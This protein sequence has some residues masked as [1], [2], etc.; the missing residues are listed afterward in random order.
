MN[1]DQVVQ[2]VSPY[3]VKIET[4]TGHG[5]GF[6]VLYPDDR[7]WCGV[8]TAAHVVEYA[9]RWQQPIRVRHHLSNT[10]TLLKEGERVI[11]I[12]S[13]TDSAVILF[14]HQH[15]DLPQT[16][17]PLLPLDRPLPI[18]VEVGW[19]GFPSIAPFE[20]CFFAGTVSARRET[21]RSY[22]LDGVAINGVSGGP[23][24]F[25]DETDGT[26]I[27]GVVSA[28]APNRATGDALPGL[29]IA[30]DVSHFHGVTQHIRSIDDAER[31]KKE[32]QEANPK[33]TPVIPGLE[34]TG[35]T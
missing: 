27:V 23:V 2:R 32:F 5:T 3:V 20:L 29:A 15:L 28:Y 24:I 17:I 30:Q 31:K 21:Y 8:A 26:H 33:G 10:E 18:G 35:T 4:P 9:E 7:N 25:R 22:L 34:S 11:F 6:L 16:L 13:N 1:W 12:D 14:Q 19:L